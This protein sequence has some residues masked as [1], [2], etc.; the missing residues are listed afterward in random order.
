MVELR[1]IRAKRLGF[2]FRRTLR[3][4]PFRFVSEDSFLLL[5]LYGITRP[6]PSAKKALPARAAAGAQ[7]PAVNDAGLPWGNDDPNAPMQPT[8]LSRP[9]LIWPT[10][11]YQDASPWDQLLQRYRK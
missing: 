7:I 6:A 10:K 2:T 4:D 9:G 8:R 11:R 5:V 1:E 3:R